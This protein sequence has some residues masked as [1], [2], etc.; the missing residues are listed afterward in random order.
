MR[1]Q[2][3]TVIFGLVIWGVILGGILSLSRTVYR[4]FYLSEQ[5]SLSLLVH[6]PE[7]E[8]L[9]IQGQAFVEGTPVEK[10]NDGVFSVR[11]TPYI[12]QLVTLERPRVDKG[13][14]IV[15]PI[16]GV[17]TLKFVL[18]AEGLEVLGK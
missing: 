13:E 16:C 14:L 3:L 8:R 2:I 17:G 9:V 7:Q 15:R 18:S 6:F 1:R 4:A 5:V 11:L 10:G 12:R